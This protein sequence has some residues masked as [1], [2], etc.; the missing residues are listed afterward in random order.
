[1]TATIR[2]AQL[3][4]L[5]IPFQLAITHASHTR[6]AS[7]SV[8]LRL[9]TSEGT[10]GYGE[11]VPRPYVTGETVKSV[12]DSLE[13]HIREQ[14]IGRALP[15]WQGDPRQT[16]SDVEPLLPSPSQDADIVAAH[17]ARA[18]LELALLDCVTSVASESLSALLP[19]GAASVTYSGML[20]TLSD[21]RALELARM[22]V[23]YGIT[24]IK[25]KVGDD[26]DVARV[27]L[28]REELGPDFELYVDANCAW[29]MDQ[30]VQRIDQLTKLGV[31]LV[32]QPIPRGDVLDL[33]RLREGISVPIMADESLITLG[34]ARALIDAKACD[35]F[36]IRISKCGGLGNCMRLARMAEEAGLEYQ[37]GAHVGETA[38]LSAAGRHLGLALRGARYVEGSS[39]GFLLKEDVTAI[40]L[41]FEP[42][43]KGRPLSGPG[44]GVDVEHSRLK[45]LSCQ[46]RTIG[47][48][49]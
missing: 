11:A 35:I 17:A 23:A 38:I 29:T 31:T 45:R 1:M 27:R 30:A 24:R 36:N 44:L 14:L 16:F 9:E 42:G 13:Q 28:L 33:A 18:A 15:D 41:Q 4:A 48:T 43:A 5:D 25:V 46:H 19:E 32:E 39:G 49:P 12:M 10:V 20:P 2:S 26:N 34:D 8:V 3:F 7:D 22:Q 40:P 37:L 6:S 47:G 21:E